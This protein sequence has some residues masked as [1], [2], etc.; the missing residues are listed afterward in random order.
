LTSRA[1][2]S[3]LVPAPG[4]TERPSLRRYLTRRRWQRREPREYV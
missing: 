3:L 1:G 4:A 2:R